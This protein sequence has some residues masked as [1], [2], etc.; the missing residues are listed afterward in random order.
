MQIAIQMSKIIIIFIF[1]AIASVVI[2][3]LWAIEYNIYESYFI[4]IYKVG[5]AKWAG[6]VW[7]IARG[8]YFYL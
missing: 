4:S 6:R 7:S 5:G 8:I 3:L 2:A 1:S